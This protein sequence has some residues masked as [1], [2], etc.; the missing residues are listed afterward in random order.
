M[1]ILKPGDRVILNTCTGPLMTV[2][3]IN[4]ATVS[5]IWF[6]HNHHR[7]TAQFAPETLMPLGRKMEG[8]HE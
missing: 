8:E 6:D 1:T 5:C 7:Q 3:K 2:N 4:K